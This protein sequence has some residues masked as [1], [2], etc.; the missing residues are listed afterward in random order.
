MGYMAV[1]ILGDSES[2]S[3]QHSATMT[4]S[5]S[6]SSGQ[7]EAVQD[8]IKMYETAIAGCKE[9]SKS[10]RYKRAVGTMQG[11]LKS[12]QAG[13]AVDLEQLPAPIST[14]AG[15]KEKQQTPSAGNAA[16]LPNDKEFE[17]S[18]EEIAA[19]AK[20][21][22]DDREPK[23]T[24]PT[25]EGVS[26]GVK[27]TSPKSASGSQVDMI[28]SRIKLYETVIANCKESSRTHRYKR[29]VTLM[30]SMLKEAKAGKAV[31][32]D[33]L[34]SP[35]TTENKSQGAA[36]V[37]NVA[38]SDQM[39]QTTAT[40]SSIPPASSSQPKMV[41]PVPKPRTAV[42]SSAQPTSSQQTAQPRPSPKPRA[43]QQALNSSDGA[44]KGKK[45]PPPGW[46]IPMDDDDDEFDIT[47]EDLA[48]MATAFVDDRVKKP[49]LDEQTDQATS[50][51]KLAAAV[52]KQP[53][54]IATSGAASASTITTGESN[55]KKLLLERKSQYL[56][57]AQQAQTKGDTTNHKKHQVRAL[58]FNKVLAAF[59]NG[60]EIDLSQMPGPPPGFKSTIVVD[61][62]QYMPNRSGSVKSTS[63]AASNAVEYDENDVDDSIP[64]PKT[65][66][67]ALE[68]R[69]EKYKKATDDAKGKGEGSKA[70]RM[71]RIVKQ[72]DDAIKSTK[73]GKPFNY[74]DLPTPPGYPPIP[75]DKKPAAATV[76][77]PS[78]SLQP[79]PTAAAS[80]QP[81]PHA[82]LPP[83][84]KLRSSV[85][86][87]QLEYLKHRMETFKKAAM[88]ARD[89]GNRQEAIHHMTYYKSCQKMIEAALQ[90]LPVDLTQL[91]PEVKSSSPNMG[92]ISQ[93]RPATEADARTFQLIEAQLRSQISIC[94]KYADMYTA[95]QSMGAVA[96][97]RN[98]EQECERDLLALTGI[99]S[100]GKAPPP[101]TTELKEMSVAVANTDVGISECVVQVVQAKILQLPSGV[102]EKDLH[103]SVTVEFPY[104]TED[105]P[106]ANT[107]VVKETATPQFNYKY[108][109]LLDRDHKRSIVRAFKRTPVKF[110]IFHQSRGFLRTKMESIGTAQVKLETF[111]NECDISTTAP[112]V[113][114]KKPIGGELDVVISI[115]EPL[116]GPTQKIVKEKW[117]VFTEKLIQS[118]PVPLVHSAHLKPVG[119]A[120]GKVGLQNMLVPSPAKIET[121]TSIEA[122]KFELTLVQE[123][124]KQGG[125]QD[126]LVKRQQLILRKMQETKSQMAR[127]GKT[128]QCLYAQK[129]RDDISR[130]TATIEQLSKAGKKDLALIFANRKKKMEN[131]LQTLQ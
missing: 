116:S 113:V 50:S 124:I 2:I 75:V 109:F 81:R 14:T 70:R 114:G 56:A 26:A 97:F 43:T 60:Q 129:I 107:D 83:Q 117:I 18:E 21:F 112:I 46:N 108:S 123:L 28:Q 121:T 115:R 119:A 98:L 27:S 128:F 127:G 55:V 59:D 32:L 40:S 71:G 34:P 91:P 72:Y 38:V 120:T 95:L 17:I 45:L 37:S 48:K 31:N 11:M 104:P 93:L 68:Q 105:S 1:C 74:A 96:Q 53:S 126:V 13:K 22:V 44:G 36:T 65:V 122:L 10:R 87:K 9:A 100:Q 58:Q 94:K 5:S 6:S 57:A 118:S 25:Q 16:K 61:T 47:E 69:I 90:G 110:E 8:R 84:T 49:R 19:L 63:S 125:K 52:H 88:T 67:E 64:K 15:N 39:F 30:Q 76:Q 20:T 3:T 73:L 101:F 4:V 23:T 103:L 78:A 79:R 85:N 42:P 77:N 66:L 33:D 12:I 92:L 86:D 29:S 99:Q 106:K 62:A 130:E 41:A 102:A 80:M 82:S 24:K 51:V 89:G 131:E 111:E 35:P 54:P 7:L